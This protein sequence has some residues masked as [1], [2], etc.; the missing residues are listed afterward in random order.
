MVQGGAARSRSIRCDRAF[1]LMTLRPITLPGD[2]IASK[3][4]VSITHADVVV[5]LV[6]PDLGMVCGLVRSST[7]VVAR[8][9]ARRCTSGR[10]ILA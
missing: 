5:I 3:L 4:T 8:P 6:G 7:K 9:R 2:P 10:C 1:P